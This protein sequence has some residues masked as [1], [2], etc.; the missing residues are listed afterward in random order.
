[1]NVEELL[2]DSYRK[3]A[4][5][6]TKFICKHPRFIP[7]LI[8]ELENKNQVLAMRT[9]RVFQLCYLSCPNLIKPY[10]AQLLEILLSTKIN[11][12]CRNLLYIFQLTWKYL[13]EE[14]FG[15]LL[16]FSFQTFENVQAEPALRI[17]AL[18]ILN[19]SFAKIPEIK[20][21]L[22]RLIEFH[23]TEGSPALKGVIRK[24]TKQNY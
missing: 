8:L 15:Y 3:T 2:P 10:L 14:Q 17:Y 13:N 4:D 20:E 23:Y 12:V 21:E 6:A 5:L 16:N 18:Y 19:N 24:L 11:G 1:M 9:S 7:M 22:S